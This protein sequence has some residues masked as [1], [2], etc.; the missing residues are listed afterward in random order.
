MAP[1]GTSAS[2]FFLLFFSSCIAMVFFIWIFSL[3]RFLLN[4]LALENGACERV[5]ENGASGCGRRTV[6]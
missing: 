1:S 2:F 5:R 4:S 6:S 3:W